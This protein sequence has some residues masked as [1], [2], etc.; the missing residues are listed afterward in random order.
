MGTPRNQLNIARKAGRLLI[1]KG[2]FEGDKNH[3][4]KEL[5]DI[6]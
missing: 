3:L 4:I 1:P 6:L 2:Q 5:N